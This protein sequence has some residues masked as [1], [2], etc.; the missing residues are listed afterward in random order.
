M[1]TYVWHLPKVLILLI[2]TASWSVSQWRGLFS[3][4][5]QHCLDVCQAKFPRC[6]LGVTC[7]ERNPVSNISLINLYKPLTSF[8]HN[9]LADPEPPLALPFFFI[10]STYCLLLLFWVSSGSSSVM[11]MMDA[12]VLARSSA[13]SFIAMYLGTQW[14][15]T[16][17]L[18]SSLLSFSRIPKQI[19]YWKDILFC[20]RY[21]MQVNLKTSPFVSP[22]LRKWIRLL[23]IN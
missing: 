5:S 21:G 8:N 12:F 15:T 11:N 13:L 23:L 22:M 17:L 20:F 2:A 9:S 7:L 16:M 19:V 1:V 14:R 4:V 3:L 18:L 10:V 6:T